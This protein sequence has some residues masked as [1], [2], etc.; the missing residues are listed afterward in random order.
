MAK[1]TQLSIPFSSQALIKR[2]TLCA[3]IL[4]IAHIVLT[5]MHYGF[6]DLPWLLRELFDVDEEESIPTWFSSMLLLVTSLTLFLVAALCK[7]S[8]DRNAKYWVGLGAG[9]AFMSADEIAGFHETLNTVIQISWAVP[10]LVVALIIGGMY[11]KFLSS[12]PSATAVRFMMSGAIFVGGAVGVEL[13]TEPY[14][15]NDALDTMA[16]NLWTPVEEGMEIG[17]VIL[18]LASIFDYMKTR[19]GTQIVFMDKG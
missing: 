6:V 1:P 19:F 8:K 5:V 14:L 13:A 3:V 4:L 18:F 12:L 9:F 2:L 16:Y 17:G 10:G 15:Y 7:Q 11:L